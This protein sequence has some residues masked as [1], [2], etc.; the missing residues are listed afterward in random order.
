MFI[1]RLVGYATMYMLCCILNEDI[2]DE[3]SFPRGVCVSSTRLLHNRQVKARTK[4]R[5]GD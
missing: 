5:R 4:Q 1:V 3:G 2:A